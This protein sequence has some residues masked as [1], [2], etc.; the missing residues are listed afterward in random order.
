M[1]DKMFD[2]MVSTIYSFVI[3]QQTFLGHTYQISLIIPKSRASGNA[4]VLI[5]PLALSLYVECF[6]L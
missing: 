1:I 6:A 3:F 2:N 5:L 4:Q